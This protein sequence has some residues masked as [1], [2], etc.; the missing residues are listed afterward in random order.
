LPAQR[1]DANKRPPSVKRN[2]TYALIMAGG[3]GTRFWP[4]S[5]KAHPKQVLPI[6]GESTLIQQ[7]VERIRRLVPAENIFVIT[8]ESLRAE[9]VRQLPEVPGQQIIAE[10]IARNTAPCIGLGAKLIRQRD[11]QALMGVFPADHAVTNTTRFVSTLRRAF[12]AAASGDL[13]VVGIP[14]RWPE[15][16]Y[17]YLEFPKSSN[18]TSNPVRLKRF[19]EKPDL[20]TAK[21]FVKAG[22]YYW[23]SGMFFWRAEA[24]LD[25]INQHLPRTALHLESLR[26]FGSKGFDRDLAE[27]YPLCENVSVDFGVMEKADNVSAVVADDFGW[28]DVG[29]WQAVYELARK[30]ALSNAVRGGSLLGLDARGNYVDA[31]KPVALLGVEDLVVVETPDAL[32]ITRRSEAHRVGELVKLL[33]K[34]KQEDLL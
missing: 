8:S 27:M 31:R 16:G 2:H 22:N 17:G 9:L 1:Q 19:R 30:D 21:R 12:K 11:P 5:R 3:R 25:A 24:F 33:E 29:S 13:V 34:Q 28:S 10:P 23:N 26:D 7:T 4:L 15:T 14:P 20:A 6:L 18:D 32:L